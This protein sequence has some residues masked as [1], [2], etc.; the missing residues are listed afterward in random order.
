MLLHKSW[1]SHPGGNAKSISV[2]LTICMRQPVG[3]A[4]AQIPLVTPSW[5]GGHSYL[6]H[7][8]LKVYSRSRKRIHCVGHHKR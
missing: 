4:K 6:L 2:T 3:Q 8:L 7:P 1:T 5:G